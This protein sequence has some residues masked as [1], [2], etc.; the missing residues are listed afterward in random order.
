MKMFFPVSLLRQ[1]EYIIFLIND[2]YLEV[3]H[4]YKV[5][6]LLNHFLVIVYFFLTKHAIINVTQPLLYFYTLLVRFHVCLSVIKSCAL[7]LRH[8]RNG[9]FWR[10]W[11]P[12]DQTKINTISSKIQLWNCR[13][14]L[15][16]LILS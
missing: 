8:G 11:D 10:G 15:L 12:P 4:F 7:D 2:N 16:P 13:A 1:V 6:K 9:G 3:F 14:P 5:S